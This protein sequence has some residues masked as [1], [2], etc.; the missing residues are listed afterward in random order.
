MCYKSS[1]PCIVHLTHDNNYHVYRVQCILEHWTPCKTRASYKKEQWVGWELLV[2]GSL[3]DHRV[4][5]VSVGEVF[6]CTS[7]F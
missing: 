6:L 3:V 7:W 4:V 2:C 5:F 1:A